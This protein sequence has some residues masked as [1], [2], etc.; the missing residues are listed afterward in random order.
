MFGFFNDLIRVLTDIRKELEESN[1]LSAEGL[2]QNKFSSAAARHNEANLIKIAA[3]AHG[4]QEV[5]GGYIHP[6]P[7][8]AKETLLNESER[9]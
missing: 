3:C 2:L 5:E 9:K 6:G 7:E 8:P 1:R 4:F